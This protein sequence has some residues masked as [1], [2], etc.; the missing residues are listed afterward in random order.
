MWAQVNEL[1]FRI[2]FHYSVSAGLWRPS[3][4]YCLVADTRPNRV[5]EPS[6]GSALSVS[7]WINF[8]LNL[9]VSGSLPNFTFPWSL[10]SLALTVLG[11]HRSLEEALCKSHECSL[12]LPSIRGLKVAKGV[13]IIIFSSNNSPQNDEIVTDTAKHCSST[14]PI[15]IPPPLPISLPASTPNTIRH[16]RLTVCL[17][18]SLDLTICLSILFYTSAFE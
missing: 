11:A 7:Q 10:S 3:T 15:L 17:P 6:I 16:S 1:L 8:K 18:D 9:L 14:N 4:E 2:F 5:T 12:E 13:Y